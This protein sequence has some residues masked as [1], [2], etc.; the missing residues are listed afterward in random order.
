MMYFKIIFSSPDTVMVSKT[1]VRQEC[2]N[3]CNMIG[4]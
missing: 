2:M 4:I 3:I 1:R